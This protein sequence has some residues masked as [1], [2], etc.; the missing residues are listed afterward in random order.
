[1]KLPFQSKESICSTIENRKESKGYSLPTG[2]GLEA[3][4]EFGHDTKM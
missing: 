3:F 2:F 1:M 4:P